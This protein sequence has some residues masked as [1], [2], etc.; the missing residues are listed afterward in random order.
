MNVDPESL[1][2]KLDDFSILHSAIDILNAVKGYG[3][4]YRYDTGCLLPEMTM[5]VSN[6]GI[7]MGQRRRRWAIL[8]LALGKRIVNLDN[9]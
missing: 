7:M 1:R 8:I 4:E 6:A 9:Q 5:R 3:V 2:G